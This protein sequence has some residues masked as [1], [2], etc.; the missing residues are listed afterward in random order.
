MGIIKKTG[1]FIAIAAS[2]ITII[3]FWIQVKPVKLE[4]TIDNYYLSTPTNIAVVPSLIG[5]FKFEGKEVKDLYVASVQF[6]NTGDSTIIG[7][8]SR[9]NIIK[10][11]LSFALPPTYK[12]L[13][14]HEFDSPI[15][16]GIE[17]KD[18]NKFNIKLSQLRKDERFILKIYAEKEYK[19]NIDFSVYSVNRDLVDGNIVSIDTFRNNYSKNNLTQIFGRNTRTVLTY[20]AI[21]LS[22]SMLLYLLFSYELIIDKVR[23]SNWK[24]KNELKFGEYVDN[25]FSSLSHVERDLIKNDPSL[26]SEKIWERFEGDSADTINLIFKSYTASI[27][28]VVL[29]CSLA[30][31]IAAIL[32]YLS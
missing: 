12:I 8:G 30:L 14:V 1:S 2:I 17:V 7:E 28:A 15:S 24:K 9:K 29:L 21:S 10:E 3:A 4:L 22:I 31:G 23:L 18:E 26:V 16:V 32:I 6:I 5:S 11:S 13:S 25:E 19:N 20:G 27:F